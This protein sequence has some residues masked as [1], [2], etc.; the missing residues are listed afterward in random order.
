VPVPLRAA[1]V[2]VA[3]GDGFTCVALAGGELDCW[4]RNDVGELGNG[5][6]GVEVAPVQVVG[7]P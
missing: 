7:T 4:G 5:R 6:S 3:A 1:V 2:S